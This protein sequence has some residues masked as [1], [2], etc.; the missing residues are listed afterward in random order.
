MTKNNTLMRRAWIRSCDES[1]M[2]T[3][4]GGLPEKDHGCLLYWRSG[5]QMITISL[6]HWLLSTCYSLG[7]SHPPSTI[8]ISHFKNLVSTCQSYYPSYWFHIHYYQ[9]EFSMTTRMWTLKAASTSLRV[10]CLPRSQLNAFVDP[11]RHQFL[12]M[13]M[14]VHGIESDMSSWYWI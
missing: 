6:E 14:W 3:T 10:T 9:Y 2:A 4:Y 12:R 13:S 1:T 5:Y 7:V 11:A 8:K